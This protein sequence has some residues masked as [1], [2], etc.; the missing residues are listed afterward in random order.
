MALSA[1]EELSVLALT[2]ASGS[3]EGGGRWALTSLTIYLGR[4]CP[5]KHAHRHGHVN[6]HR[7]HDGLNFYGS[8]PT[9]TCIRGVTRSTSPPTSSRFSLLHP[10]APPHPLS[11]SPSFS[12][13]ALLASE[14]LSGRRRQGLK[15][16][17][18]ATNSRQTAKQ[19]PHT[20][21]H[22]TRS[23]LSAADRSPADGVRLH[24]QGEA[25]RGWPPTTERHLQHNAA[26][27]QARLELRGKVCAH[28]VVAAESSRRVDFSDLQTPRG[29]QSERDVRRP[30][31]TL[32]CQPISLVVQCSHSACTKALEEPPQKTRA[33]GSRCLATSMQSTK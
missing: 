27:K 33:G 25:T 26:C 20:L 9:G 23:A 29:E 7:T 12:L 21:S 18:P 4:A 24:I 1:I 2:C 15:T 28:H 22:M 30:A 5:A 31:S 17:S 8:H 6:K 3:G 14:V 13:I 19:G 32:M 11:P 10:T 16:E